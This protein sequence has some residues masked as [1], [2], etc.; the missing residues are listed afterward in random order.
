MPERDELRELMR[1]TLAERESARAHGHA[2]KLEALI[3]LA[4][5]SYGL[6]AF[7]Q[8]PDPIITATLALVLGN[9]AEAINLYLEALRQNRSFPDEK[10][11]EWRLHLAARFLPTGEIPHA[12]AELR[13]WR[14]QADSPKRSLMPAGR[15]KLRGC[16]MTRPFSVAFKQKMVQRLTGKDAVSAIQAVAGNRSATTERLRDRSCRTLDSA[17]AT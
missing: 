13:E 3:E 1:S 4:R 11:Y 14:A 17:T 7:H 16:D 5:A 10:S 12:A 8:P 9:S 2:N 15:Q 6:Q